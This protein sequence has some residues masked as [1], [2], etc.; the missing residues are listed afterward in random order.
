MK[1]IYGAPFFRSR[2]IGAYSYSNC[3]TLT[4]Q[5]ACRQ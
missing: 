5:A 1:K 4:H 3:V 2:C